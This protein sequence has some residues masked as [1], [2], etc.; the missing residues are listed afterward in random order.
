MH[1]FQ[2][3]SPHTIFLLICICLGFDP[4]SPSF[5]PFLDLGQLSQTRLRCLNEEKLIQ[6]LLLNEDHSNRD[7]E[8]RFT[9]ISNSSVI[10]L[11]KPQ[12]QFL[13]DIVVDF[14][15]AESTALLRDVFSNHS[16]SIPNTGTALVF[17]ASS[18]SIIGYALLSH[19]NIRDTRKGKDLRG[20]I[21][22][23]KK[24]VAHLVARQ[25][26]GNHLLDGILESFI[27]FLG[28]LEEIYQSKTLKANGVIAMAHGFN[29]DFWERLRIAENQLRID[30]DDAM[31]LDNEFESQ[32]SRHGTE[33]AE[34]EIS[35]NEID[36]STDSIAFQ[37]SSIAKICF[38]S[39]LKMLTGD[40]DLDDP[41]DAKEFM[42][43][44]VSLKPRDFLACRPFI[45][46][47][48]EAKIPVSKENANLLFEYLVHRI[49]PPYEFE[50]CEVSMGFCLEIMTGLA[51]MWTN[52][53]TDDISDLGGSLYE[54]FIKVALNHGISSP[55]VHSGISSMLQRVIKV[56][57]EYA[58][59]RSDSLPSARTS[60]FRVLQEGNIRV[61]F[62]VGQNISEIFGL[63]VL[64][65]H[66]TILE[67]VIR[68]LPSMINWQEGIALRLFVLAHLAASW[69]TLLRRCV[70]AIFETPGHAYESAGHAKHCLILVSKSLGLENLQALFKLFVSQIIYTWLETQPLRSIPYSIFGYNHLAELLRDVQDEVIG[71]VV[72]RG[73]DDEAIQLATDLEKPYGQ[74][75]E[76]SF[77]KAAAYSIS[78]DVAVPPSMN[79][80][81]PGAE[82]RL[83]KTLGKELH[84][85][86]INKHFPEILA[87][88]Y[89]TLDEVE[90]IQKGF[91]KHPEYT[92]AQ[93][94]YQKLISISASETILPVNQQP[95]FRARYLI[96]EIEFLCR[97]TRYEP[98]SIWSPELYVYVFRELLSTINPALGSLHA[99][100]VLRRIRL[101]VCMAGQTALDFYPLEMALHSLRPYITNTHCAED[102]IGIFQ[103][104]I[105]Y[106][107]MYIKEIP[108]FLA[109]IAISTLTSMKVFLK[110][111]QESTTQESQ[112]RAT[113]STAHRFHAWF[114]NYLDEYTSPYL[115]GASKQSF[116]ALV[117][118]ARNARSTGNPRHGTYE[119][120]LLLEILED[121]RSG[122]CILNQPAQDLIL[123]LLCTEFEVLSSFRDDILG[124][125][126]QATL[127]APVVWKT[128]RRNHLGQNY[129]L[130]VGK[131][132]GRAYV[133]T[134][135]IDREM[136]LETQLESNEEKGSTSDLIMSQ[137]SR[138]SIL[139]LL[140]DIV[141]VDNPA[142]V[143][144][145]E[146][147]LR[148]IVTKAG[149][150]EFFEECEQNISHSLMKSLVWRQ[151]QCPMSIS[152]VSSYRSLQ[153]IVRFDN[154][155][156]ALRWIQDLCIALASIA[157]DD[158]ILS[159][160]PQILIRME[161]FAEK[162][163]PYILHLV[164][165][166]EVDSP[167][168]TKRTISDACS[169]W[170]RNC[171]SNSIP[172][173]KMLL[174]AILYLRKQ[175]LPHEAT[176]SDRSRWLEL[177]FKLAAEAATKCAMFKTALLFLDINHS[178]DAKASRRSSK[179][180]F[181]EPTD[182]LL[183]IFR[184]I[185]EQDAFY[186]VQQPSSL[187]SM[188]SRLEYENAG[189]KSLSFRGA[190]YDSHIRL[191]K[192]AYQ[193]DE[194]SIVK[195]LDTLDLNGLSQSLL[196]KM[197]NTGPHSIDSMLRTARKLEQW[198]LSA[199]VSHISST[200]IVFRAFQSI[201]NAANLENIN[202]ALSLG[203]KGSM[204]LLMTGV[205]ADSSLQTTLSTLSILTEADEIFSSRNAQDLQEGWSRLVSRD[206]WM[207]SAR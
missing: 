44:L 112:F 136:T 53:D 41:L 120:D 7:V 207:E 126:E 150:A 31:D 59:T 143:G 26:I 38:L 179:N 195:I 160:L 92:K 197:T 24:E 49:L 70:Y 102:T 193:E 43:Y 113:M 156:P 206:T 5:R 146:T 171:E 200:G 189:F 98:Q 66:D 17:V 109:G 140:C 40:E 181:E 29:A 121:Q 130:W 134:G 128:C 46:E 144:M 164:L 20:A 4:P 76:C 33:I 115:S 187:S 151:Y 64:T 127:Y 172:H 133:S 55:H 178:E 62:H 78:R 198:D 83:R 117:K 96:D 203:F 190:H 205:T 192:G 114:A 194:G 91:Q 27:P 37:N 63:F 12:F 13:S 103:Y 161:N 180:K 108:S 204:K 39:G 48:F 47:L 106:G 93:E 199:P 23:L 25:D 1:N 124:S 163:F 18:L 155:K 201:N 141:L 131:V 88:F 72:M 184:N 65:E 21:D 8:L 84:T 97:R 122:R 153:E 19:I 90:D 10:N 35:R 104:L 22:K 45:R 183:N 111:T 175:P 132:L 162:V 56:R 167:Q 157:A 123:A 107:N 196:S 9:A 2:H 94:S 58:R 99:C 202:S 170:F 105:E 186:G 85:S 36:A 168:A 69:P 82:A 87:C 51:E 34:S 79:K 177:D 100:S 95:S 165:Q 125:S 68:N 6:Y 74:L 149:G 81:A 152:S 73:K 142:E 32:G 176:K 101:L 154:S 89:K 119:S 118:A 71:Q 15:L 182:L 14:L 16:E 169:Q 28:P 188:M 166:K 50:R 138:S 110:S 52:N 137:S 173:V 57:P 116:K 3:Y 75:L 148:S 86:L 147:V 139:R 191:T 185:D 61:K 80:Q 67:D 159:E 60:L 129:L 158:P 30:K 54:W 42:H 77:S 145:A 135:L 11:S 174:R